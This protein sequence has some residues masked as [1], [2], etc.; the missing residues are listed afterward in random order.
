ME[1][2]HIG[3]GVY[4]SYDGFHINIAVNHHE[5]HVVALDP[6]V[7]EALIKYHEHII[8]SREGLEQ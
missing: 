4:V 8:K 5:N 2:K 6:E 1:P 7:M 3:D